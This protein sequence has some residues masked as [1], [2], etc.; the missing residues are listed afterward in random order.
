MTEDIR[1]FDGTWYADPAPHVLPGDLLVN[2]RYR[3]K[4]GREVGTPPIVI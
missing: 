3:V 1:G 2:N 4:I